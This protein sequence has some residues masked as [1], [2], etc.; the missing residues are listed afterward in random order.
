[1]AV[2]GQFGRALTGSGSLAS[3]ISSIA[4]EFVT[5]RTNRIYD[6]YINEEALDGTIIDAQTAIA[7]LKK[8]MAGTTADTRAG[9]GISDMIRAVR[10]ANRTRTLNK[11]D[12]DLVE[13]G[14]EK[15]DYGKMVT[16]I[17]E[18]LLDPTLNPDDEAELRKELA[19]AVQNLFNNN[20]NQFN[21]GGKITFNGKTIDFANGTNYE[22]FLSVYDQVARSSPEMADKI[23]RQKYEGEVSV[24]IAQANALWLSSTRTTDSQKLQGYTAQLGILRKAYDKLKAQGLDTGETGVDLL[25]QIRS[26]ESSEA[27]A[28]S[29]IG[30]ASTNKRIAGLDTEVYGG[31]YDI[32]DALALMGVN[33][34][35]GGIA[36]M[37][38]KNPNAAYNAIDMAIA[39]NGGSTSITVNGKV[40][41]ID[42]DTI[43]AVIADTK[44]AAVS[45]NNW[46]KNNPNVSASN[47]IAIRNYVTS[48][49]AL[50]N[51]VPNLKVEDAYDNARTTLETALEANPDDI[52][53]RVNA[54]KAFGKAIRALSGMTT[55]SAVKTALAAEADLFES[56]KQP[57]QGVMV[58]GEWSG[59]LERGEGG[60]SALA[61]G[62]PLGRLINPR[63]D[64]GDVS[65]SEAIA[66]IYGQHQTFNS[67]GGQV[68]IDGITG[69]RVATAVA[70]DVSAYDNGQGMGGSTIVSNTFG[71]VDVNTQHSAVYA[72][73]RIVN[74]N[75]TG[76]TTNAGL[77]NA[78]VGWISVITDDKGNPIEVVL[79][80]A[81]GGGTNERVIGA[82]AVQ[83][84]LQTM[85]MSAENIPLRQV[86]NNT[87]VVANQAFI[88]AMRGTK[89]T[90]NASTADITN[91]D[92]DFWDRLV[93]KGGYVSPTTF[94]NLEIDA[95]Y[96]LIDAGKI[97]T[98]TGKNGD[99][100]VFVAGSGSGE[101]K[102]WTNITTSL[103]PELLGVV[104]DA[105]KLIDSGAPSPG[106]IPT[107]NEG[108]GGWVNPQGDGGV[109]YGGGGGGGAGGG[110]VG[111][112]RGGDLRSAIN[113]ALERRRNAEFERMARLAPE[114]EGGQFRPT[115]GG[116]KR[117][118]GVKPPVTPVQT[119]T[120]DGYAAIEKSRENQAM[121]GT[122]MRNLPTTSAG[123]PQSAS[124]G[125][126]GKRILGV[127]RV[128]R[129][130]L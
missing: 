126:Q 63:V 78:T 35:E 40:V 77:R 3:A 114:M 30:Q 100:L 59:N 105:Q 81:A 22:Q 129:K 27:T 11:L 113:E 16:A 65:I 13:M 111:T 120:L 53:A 42:R 130:A 28:K 101:N 67:G 43:Y 7:E 117:T 15:G 55:S 118:T 107:G 6:A 96:K 24:A 115:V 106:D 86:G 44:A 20:K 122:F 45:A 70:E 10:K 29:N 1:M 73:Y 99:V 21:A 110:G 124:T 58:Y 5:L 50:F 108:D 52:N 87:V 121:L 72:R 128:A 60:E 12:A 47:K 25:D 85:G 66:L 31:L 54:L 14:A 64:S 9:Q 89:D 46:A 51:N 119:P 61:I 4:S 104:R 34:G 93:T 98:T 82:S 102:V 94:K 103:S 39:M 36:G 19:T 112:T 125:A 23:T 17:Q 116:V 57:K 76:D 83:S 123:T 127:E 48:S 88:N 84:I 18:M 41:E 68:Y 69:E 33:T 97:K 2:T 32:D 75:F 91:G 92:S 71:G 80:D 37:L 56:G 62:S 79:F 95:F 109:G 8:L 74:Q 26:L 38:L 49:T 90:F